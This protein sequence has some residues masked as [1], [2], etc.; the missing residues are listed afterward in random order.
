MCVCVCVFYKD[1]DFVCVSE[2]KILTWVSVMEASGTNL[3]VT[4]IHFMT[5]GASVV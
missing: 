4:S 2:L 3:Q 1:F 5:R